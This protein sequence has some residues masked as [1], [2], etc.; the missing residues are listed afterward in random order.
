MPRKPAD[1]AARLA[2]WRKRQLDR[3]DPVAFAVMEALQARAAHYE[4]PARQVL[5]QR[6]AARM[7]AYGSRLPRART[8]DPDPASR[9]VT[10]L[11]TLVAELAQ[12]PPARRVAG[13]DGD[14]DTSQILAAYPSLSALG[15][16]R[17]LWASVRSRGQVR[18]SLA[19][20]PS[21]G[22]PLNSAVLVHRAMS[23]MG[24]VSPGYLKHCLAYLDNLSWL[25]QLQPR[26]TAPAKDVGRIAKPRRTR[27]ARS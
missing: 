2:D 1:P 21:D 17:A 8:T 5:E 26:A 7:A 9:C 6:L 12:R 23:F 22:G 14:G 18:Q 24:E 11:A 3:H 25:E 10:P 16:F 19:A 4:G 15:E 13:G 20:T 27:P